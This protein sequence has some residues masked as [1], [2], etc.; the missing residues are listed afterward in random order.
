MKM[1]LAVV[2][3]LV[4][5]GC[6]GVERDKAVAKCKAACP[7]YGATYAHATRQADSSME[8]AWECWCRRGAES[9]GGSEP[10]RIW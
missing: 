5:V 4:A 3:M 6:H 7:Q 10:L 8:D 1:F 2:V 9:G